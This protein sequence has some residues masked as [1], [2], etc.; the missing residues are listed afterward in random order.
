MNSDREDNMTEPN[1]NDRRQPNG[2]TR[3]TA[4]GRAIPDG[5][6]VRDDGYEVSDGTP[7]KPGDDRDEPTKGRLTWFTTDLLLACSLKLYWMTCRQKGVRRMSGDQWH[8]HVLAGTTP[9]PGAVPAVTLGNAVAEAI[10]SV[11]HGRSAP[12]HRTR[13]R[14]LERWLDDD[15]SERLNLRDKTFDNI[16]S[17]EAKTL[18]EWLATHFKLST[19]RLILGEMKRVEREAVKDRRAKERPFEDLVVED[20]G[21]A[22]DDGDAR[23]FLPAERVA[24]ALFLPWLYLLPYLIV[25]ALG[26]RRSELFGLRL[27]DW[28]PDARVLHVRAQRQH[29][30]T[31]GRTKTKTPASKRDVPVPRAL[32][33]AIDWYVDRMHPPRP[34]GGTELVEWGKRFLIV[35]EKGG[36]MCQATFVEKILAAFFHLGLTEERLGG[37]VKPIH[38]SR[39]TVINELQLDPDVSTEL[40]DDCVGHTDGTPAVRKKHYRHFTIAQKAPFLASIQR[41]EDEFIALL[42]TNRLLA[43]S[44][45]TDPCTV[46]ETCSIL[47]CT[48]DELQ[49]FITEGTLRAIRHDIAAGPHLAV[50]REDVYEL[51]RCLARLRLN[52]YSQTE[53]LAVLNI[54]HAKLRRHIADGVLHPVVDDGAR[55]VTAGRARPLVGGGYRFAHVEVHAIV[56]ADP[57]SF[58]RRRTWLQVGQAAAELGCS[59]DTVRRLADKG[60]LECWVDP[61]SYRGE[62]Y[63]SPASVERYKREHA[64]MTYADAIARLGISLHHLRGLVKMGVLRPARARGVRGL[65]PGV[66]L[67]DVERYEA[68]VGR[69]A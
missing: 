16:P 24:V 26:L 39:M 63:I 1:V 4:S 34:M 7:F 11:G 55:R 51:Q 19:A 14:A 59:T 9:T 58:A 50:E 57:I 15:N 6:R 62:R 25:D 53:V 35:G 49:D 32:A 61:D 60:D 45:I 68:E 52:T 44:P 30:E 36:A 46:S 17:A 65:R 38:H 20:T 21:E 3:S 18:P 8:A 28:D 56:Q 42:G 54:S 47:Q 66:L 64:S 5:V 22:D 67:S 37:R 2:T 33:A 43:P 41:R 10:E 13:L 69:A 29:S 27:G 40:I 23:G 31:R 12:H 48:L